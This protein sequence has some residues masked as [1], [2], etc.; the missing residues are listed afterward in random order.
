[1]LRVG[2]YFTLA[3]LR[4]EGIRTKST[5]GWDLSRR[6]L[7]MLNKASKLARHTRKCTLKSARINLVAYTQLD[8]P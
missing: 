8:E 7:C 1:M 3:T 6:K 2:M 5:H 4:A